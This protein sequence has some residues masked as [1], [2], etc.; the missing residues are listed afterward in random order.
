MAE[1][2]SMYFDNHKEEILSLSKEFT[3]A[4]VS[5]NQNINSSSLLGK[6]FCITGKLQVYANRDELVAEIE[7][8]GGKVVSGVT[9]KTD[10]LVTND[11]TS[12]SSK[13]V[14]AKELGIPVIT[15]ME[16]KQ[17]F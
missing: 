10:Y 14:K 12:G 5:V 16:L 8:A 9:K 1:S 13:N 4:T 6:S 15:E 3:F 7:G 17:M 11:T 2:L